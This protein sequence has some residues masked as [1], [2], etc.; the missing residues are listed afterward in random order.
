MAPGKTAPRLLQDLLTYDP[1]REERAGRNLLT[2]APPEY[3][4]S[5]NGIPAVPRG[6]C[7]HALVRKEEQSVLPATGSDDSPVH[8]V[9]S[10]C[11]QCRWHIDVI[12]SVKDQGGRQGLCGRQNAE[13]PLH[14]FVFD[15]DDE[16]ESDGIG[17]QQAPRSFSFHCTSPECST[18]VQMDLK[19]PRFTEHDQQLMM[20]KAGLRKRFQDAQG[21]IGEREGETMSRPVDGPDFLDTFL[22]DSL[23][24]VPGKTRVPLLNRKFAKTF[25]RDCDSI[26]KKLGFQFV[27]EESEKGDEEK[28]EAWYLPKPETHQD[29]FEPNLRTIIDDARFELNSMIQSVPEPERQNIRQQPMY[30]VPS[31]G[32]IE[33]MLACH[34]YEKVPGRTRSTSSTEEDHPNYASLGAVGD[35]VDP[36]IS[37][38]YRRQSAVDRPNAPYY[39]ECFQEIAIGRN[40]DTLQYDVALLASRDIPNRRDLENA[41]R[42]IGLDPVH[43]STLSDQFIID[44][45][46]SRLPDISP[47]QRQELRRHLRIIGNARDS[48]MI[49]REA[50]ESI[51]TYDEALSWLDLDQSQPDDFI[52]TMFTIKVADNPSCIESARKAVSVIAEH[53][54]SDRLRQFL[55]EGTMPEQEMD[56]SEAYALFDISAMDDRKNV[57]LSVL[58]SM[59]VVA[60]PSDVAKL[61]KAFA[62]IQHDQ[63]QSYNNRDD[64]PKEPG[65]RVND[66]PLETW[67]VGCRNNGNT[68][69]LNS[70]LQFL[71]TITPLR[72]LI[73]N[74]E[75]YEQDPSPEALRSKKVGRAVV[76]PERVVTA[77]KFVRELQSLFQLM[78]R[79]PTDNV[80][81]TKHL[82]EL[83]LCKTDAPEAEEKAPDAEG[84]AKNEM[85]NSTEPALTE[86]GKEVA[87]VA[88]T[89]MSEDSDSKDGEPEGGRSTQ[90]S[91][92]LPEL[93]DKPSPPA[94]PPPIPPRPKTQEQQKSKD[95]HIAESARQQD[96]AEVMGN[97]M[98]LISCAI[99][100][101]SIMRDG[102]QADLIKDLF[103]SDV[104]IVRNTRDKVEKTKELRNH[105]LISVGGRD[106]H[107][108]AALDDDFGLSDLEGGE[109]KYEYIEQPAPFQ[110]V[111]VRRLQ[112]NK[113]KKQQVRDTAQLQLDDVLYL[114]R[115]LETTKR[116]P[117]SELLRLR[118]AQWAKQQELR[119]LDARCKDLQVT[120]IPDIDLAD[121]VEETA[122]FTENFFKAVE[123]QMFDQLP[124]PPP[125]EL[126]V[127]LHERARVLKSELE[128]IKTSMSQLESEIDTVFREYRDH[129]YRLHAIFV[130]RGG[131]GSGHYLIYIK[132]FQNNTWR[133]YNDETVRSYSEEDIFKIGPGALAAGSTGIVFVREDH[134]DRMTQAV[135]REP[136]VAMS[137]TAT[138]EAEAEQKDV[139]MTDLPEQKVEYDSLERKPYV[140][141]LVSSL[142]IYFVGDL[143]AQS[144]A[145]P[146][147]KKVAEDEDEDER[148]WV[149]QWSE[150]RDWARTGR[151]LVIGGIS[152]IPSYK[153]FLW[154]S[155]N[156]NY[157]SKILSLTT[158]VVV[159]QILF[160][161]IFNSYF[162]GMQTLLAGASFDEIVERIKHTVPT[163]WIN[164]CK[165]WPAVTAFS[166][167]YI[168]IQYRSIFGGVIAIGWQTYL[169]L[170]NQRAA[171]Q[172][173]IEHDGA[174]KQVLTKAAVQERQERIGEKEKCAA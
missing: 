85:P 124:T 120:D 4:P 41:Y 135:V 6:N 117:G 92:G 3:T 45:T 74:F 64:Q 38:A 174:V 131:T 153:W 110:I 98:D 171:A 151:A 104:T 43:G 69:Y 39:L 63:A 109:T 86:E 163:S 97:I 33:R 18:L 54:N 147:E 75:E 138:A 113:E 20:N 37:F 145:A 106:R 61:E 30:P 169:S 48:E 111:N 13:Y 22:K 165:L 83:A 121:A 160:T 57:D 126:A 94:R 148:G 28:V 133:E 66:F 5:R 154:L 14:H 159:N 116:L 157:S 42:S 21:L 149:Q 89:I 150:D 26:L 170:L 36:L 25:W 79:A 168:P 119:R 47:P 76:T 114:D 52:R 103:F 140:T 1:R 44:Q 156:F 88:D 7:R 130:H 87:T 134:A 71:F 136:D 129:G 34:D 11:T 139:E 58:Q 167:T 123:E 8:K 102:E 166:F 100:P 72:Q 12:V 128:E 65:S 132:D 23:N 81:P 142:V 78:I 32:D 55:H 62:L 108:Y 17:G 40:S 95:D 127:D 24:P 144:I 10:Y 90:A 162:F 122:A 9:A 80:L 172:E 115:Y 173:H 105:H 125:E 51:D 118:Q 82:A 141:Q 112:F 107:L 96:A 143:V 2:S 161:P 49:Q 91:D 99:K 146:E 137:E 60:A 27:V 29:P 84:V 155:M 53:R 164:S 152:S 15:G 93:N 101:D 19:P 70:V 35:F 16:G 50:S 46:R 67:P 59:M 31:Q 73:L 158:K 56:L 68:C 77:Q